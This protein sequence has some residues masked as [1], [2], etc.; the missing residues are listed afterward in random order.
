MARALLFLSAAVGVVAFLRLSPSGRILRAS[1]AGCV[2]SLVTVSVVAAS[3]SAR[4]D[5]LDLG[6]TDV[7][8]VPLVAPTRTDVYGVARSRWRHSCSS[9]GA[10]RVD[11]NSFG[12]RRSDTNFPASA[13]RSVME[14]RDYSLPQEIPR[15]RNAVRLTRRR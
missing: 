15:T 11:A 13:T 9:A 8:V 5:L 3:E 4:R 7:R 2:P 1:F 12:L 6:F 14:P 10:R